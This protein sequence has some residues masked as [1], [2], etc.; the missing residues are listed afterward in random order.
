MTT[1]VHVVNHCSVLESLYGSIE[2]T[3][4]KDIISHTAT[5]TTQLPTATGDHSIILSE[6]N[7]EECPCWSCSV[8]STMS[9]DCMYW[10]CVL[11]VDDL[12]RVGV[13]KKRQHQSSEEGD[14]YYQLSL[15]ILWYLVT[16]VGSS[17]LRK[18]TAAAGVSGDHSRT[19]SELDHIME[20]VSL[21]LLCRYWRSGRCVR[22]CG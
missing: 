7:Q 16:Y 20:R 5:A 10:W 9:H 18:A 22:S 12:R 8:Y 17:K 15:D 11:C 21:L 2:T 1:P 13:A 14:Q 19:L 6:F 3:E 4:L